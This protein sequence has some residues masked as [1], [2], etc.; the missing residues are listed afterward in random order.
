MIRLTGDTYMA[1][2]VVGETVQTIWAS[3]VAA[4]ATA[5]F[6]RG[7]LSRVEDGVSITIPERS[8]GAPKKRRCERFKTIEQRSGL[9]HCVE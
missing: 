2:A 5:N 4:D 8:C 1:H 3:K 7:I 9:C 6:R